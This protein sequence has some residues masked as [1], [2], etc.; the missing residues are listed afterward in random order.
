GNGRVQLDLLGFPDGGLQPLLH[1]H[2]QRERP[3]RSNTTGVSAVP[4]GEAEFPN[5]G[6][7]GAEL[8]AEL[9]HELRQIRP[10]LVA[11]PD[12]LDSHP[13]HSALGLFA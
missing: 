5:R 9:A 1:A 8:A 11:L 2:W 13:D 7:N 10:T 12:P 4:Y 3:E 6:Y